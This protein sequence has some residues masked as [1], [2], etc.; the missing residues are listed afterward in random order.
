MCMLRNVRLHIMIIIYL[1]IIKNN[2][3]YE[4]KTT[5]QALR[6]VVGIL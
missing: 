4:N 6:G 3:A 5:S 1:I 2:Y